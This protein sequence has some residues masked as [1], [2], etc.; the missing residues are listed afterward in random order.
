MRILRAGIPMLLMLLVLLVSGVSTAETE[1][2]LHASRALSS[3][4]SLLEE[5][6]PFLE[7]YNR[8]TGENVRARM[9]QGVPYFW[10]ARAES[11]LFA[12]E[13][14]YIVQ[15]AWQNSPAYYRAG[16]KYLYGFDCV[17]FAAWVWKQ[18]SG[19]EMPSLAALFRD[20]ANHIRNTWTGESPL[21]DQMTEELKP[22][23]MLLLRHARSSHIAIYIGTPGMF[24]YTAAEVPELAGSLD[25]PL[26]IHCSVNA[27]IADRFADL[28]R[29]GLP[30]YRCATVTD[31]GVCVTLL[32]SDAR[33]APQM[34]HQQNQDTR[35]Y[36]LPDGTWLT[37]LGTENEAEYCWYPGPKEKQ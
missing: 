11:H 17:G 7:R 25:A 24:G 27:Q 28:I 21:W 23:D 15:A 6:N 16:Q 34:V 35:Y 31:G 2:E 22:G 14:D 4:F 30:K 12:K 3:A 36:V 20:R 5:G 37:V 18:A 19:T 32:V 8:I 26:L 1:T 13:P 29:N 33:S 10:G 9:K